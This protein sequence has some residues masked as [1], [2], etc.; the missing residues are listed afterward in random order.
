MPLESGAFHSLY[1]L[2]PSAVRVT[3]SNVSSF[4]KPF[5][6]I[7]HVHHKTQVDWTSHSIDLLLSTPANRRIIAVLCRPAVFERCDRLLSAASRTGRERNIGQ[8]ET[9]GLT[10]GSAAAEVAC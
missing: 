6:S 9:N 4:R 7:K 3:W 2:S 1:S 10:F 8:I 5:S